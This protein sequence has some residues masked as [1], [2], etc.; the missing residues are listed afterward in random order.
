MK[1]L[2]LV[3]LVASHAAFAQSKVE[4]APDDSIRSVLSRLTGQRVELR[5]KSGDK[6]AGKIE[7]MTDKVVH[8]SALSGQEFYDA[9]VLTEDV[10]AVVVRTK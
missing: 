9:V 4:L 5:L 6:L 8:L 3:L 1:K 2:L 10:S 7:K